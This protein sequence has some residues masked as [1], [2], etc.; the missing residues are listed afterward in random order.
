MTLQLTT[1]HNKI[2]TLPGYYTVYSGKATLTFWDNLSSP[3]FD[4][5]RW[6]Q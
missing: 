6:D 2:Y 4:P 1:Q 3:S 5:L